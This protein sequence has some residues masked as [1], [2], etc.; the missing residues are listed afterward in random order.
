[1]DS[2]LKRPRFPP[3]GGRTDRTLS[4]YD[5]RRIITEHGEYFDVYSLDDFCN[6]VFDNELLVLTDSI[7]SFPYLYDTVISGKHSVF[8]TDVGRP[9]MIKLVYKGQSRFVV[10]A[11]LWNDSI[12]ADSILLKGM[13]RTFN[14][15]GLGVKPTPSSIGRETMRVA[16]IDHFGKYHRYRN[17]S[18]M[19]ESFIKNTC[20]GPI[21]ATPGLG[22]QHSTA[23][24]LD[25]KSAFPTEMVQLPDGAAV[26]CQEGIA[27]TDYPLWYGLCKVVINHDIPL[28]PFPVR[29]KGVSASNV[30]EYNTRPGEYDAYLWSLQ[31]QDCI[32]VGCEVYPQHGYAWQQT[33]D[34]AVVW[35]NSMYDL[36]QRAEDEEMA[37]YI[38]VITNS[39]IGGLGGNRKGHVLVPEGQAVQGDVEMLTEY[40]EPTSF[41]IHEE[42]IMYKPFMYHWWH[43]NIARNNSAVFNFALP[44]ASDNRLLW[45]NFDAIMVTDRGDCHEYPDK[46]LSTNAPMG[47]W[48]RE[49]LHDVSISAA[50]TYKSRERVIRPELY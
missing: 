26:W 32:N 47:T 13:R 30:V 43:C 25:R 3:I 42:H 34:D 35:T 2:G 29:V 4:V 49:L 19:C 15:I 12:A 18:I 31:V 44:Y 28:G 6:A 7:P 5:G 8:C 10:R 27:L 21:V 22:T 16:W 50:R 23:V 41:Y 40:G 38:K 24:L 14:H 9:S 33:T 11:S 46:K 17:Q 20:S 36:R 1:M 37:G 39:A 45:I 48:T